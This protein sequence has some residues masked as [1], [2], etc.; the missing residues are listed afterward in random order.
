[1]KKIYTFLVSAATLIAGS[2]TGDLNQMPVIGNTSDA[3]YS[4]LSGYSSV[5]AKVYASYSIIGAE[6]GGGSPDISSIN[7]Q[8][9]LRTLFNMQEFPT[10][11]AAYKYNSGDNLT[12]ISHI[13]WNSNDIWVSDTYY[14]LYYIISLSNEF[15]RYCTEDYISRFDDATRSEIRTYA[16]EARFMRALTYSYVLDLFGKGPYVNENTPMTAYIPEAYDG[17]K[18]YEFIIS[19]IDD[20]APE[21]PDTP[22]YARAGKGAAWALGARVALNGEVYTGQSH[23]SEAIEY[24]KKVM[25][26]GYSLEPV[27]THLFNADNDKR[28][29]E[30]IFSFATDNANSATWGS[31]TYIIAG[32]CP[33]DGEIAAQYGIGTGWGSFTARG[34]FTSLFDDNDRRFLFKTENQTQYFTGNMDNADMGYWSCK[35]SNMTD[36]GEPGCPTDIG[37]TT[38]FPIFRLGEIYLTAAE[39]VLRGGSGMSRS[40]ALDL[41]NKVRERAFGDTSGNI[42]DAQLNLSFMIDERGRELYHELHR[43]SDLVRFGLFTTSSYIWQWK[44]GVI[45]GRAVDSRYNIYPI[46]MTEISANPNLKNEL[47]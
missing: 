35:W 4:S 5:L 19:E 24:C 10:D 38:D 21:L 29:N 33:A 40:E 41:V 47:Y 44:G 27:Y 37:V 31:A 8:D 16:L 15:L 9:M 26:L 14:R 20:I 1:M 45:D 43:R 30:I 46:P 23:A 6:R 18:L 28:T 25:S 36:S 7:S 42:T 13:N 17:T 39:A 3:V 32:S 22:S 34:E 11:E 2:C 12:D